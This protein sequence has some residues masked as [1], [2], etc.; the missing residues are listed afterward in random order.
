MR[1][2]KR[3]GQIIRQPWPPSGHSVRPDKVHAD[4]NP[5]T[6][7]NNYDSLRSFRFRKR[8]VSSTMV[9]WYGTMHCGMERN[10]PCVPSKCDVELLAQSH[11]QLDD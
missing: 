5:V 7:T 4:R 3:E 6:I 1:L 9:L 10:C 11:F 8:G 2:Q